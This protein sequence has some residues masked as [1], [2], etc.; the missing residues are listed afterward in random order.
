MINRSSDRFAALECF[1]FHHFFFF[2][3][4]I[5]YSYKLIIITIIVII[6][7]SSS[8]YRRI[9]LSLQR[10]ASLRLFNRYTCSGIRYERT[11]YYRRWVTVNARHCS[12]RPVFYIFTLAFCPDGRFLRSFRLVFHSVIIIIRFFKR[13]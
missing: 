12:R 1:F 11:V 9:I 5:K 4:S 10:T 3:F 13:L 2:F 6:V 8:I 7:S